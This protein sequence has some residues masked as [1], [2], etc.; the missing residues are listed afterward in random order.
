[1]RAIIWAAVSTLA[2]TTEDKFSIDDQIAMGQRIAQERG[3]QVIDTLIVPGHSRSYR[4]LDKLALDASRKNINA[5]QHLITHFERKDFDV[6]ICRDFNRFARKASLMHTIVET[7]VEDVGARIYCVVDGLMVDETNVDAITMVKGYATNREIKDLVGRRRKGMRKRAERGLA[8]HANIPF[9]HKRVFVQEAGRDKPTELPLQLDPDNAALVRHIAQLVLEGIG[10]QLIAHALYTRFGYAREDGQPFSQMRAYKFMMNPVTWGHI[11]FN[12]NYTNGKGS[13]QRRPGAW[14]WD[15]NVPPPEGVEVYRNVV[16]PAYTGELA[17]ALKAE[18][19][20]R[21]ERGHGTTGNRG[22]RFAGLCVCGGCGANMIFSMSG[23]QIRGKRYKARGYLR[24]GNYLRALPGRERCNHNSHIR[25]EKVQAEF[26]R[27][28]RI[29]QAGENPFTATDKPTN[30]TALTDIDN[31]IARLQRQAGN[32]IMQ[33]ADMGSEMGAIAREQVTRM[34]T[35]LS[36]RK[37]ERARLLAETNYADTLTQLRESSI[38]SLKATN[39]D[40]FWRGSD[41]EINQKLHILLMNYRLVISANE[42]V[43][44]RE[45]KR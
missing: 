19:Y 34:E 2:Q 37:A 5:F 6:L 3:W 26:D 15:E 11:A 1:M 4:S 43:G 40:D 36:E 18:L 12:H 16:P 39:I 7:I 28:L 27:I 32:L 38:E 10:W 41:F 30:N 45:R 8:A 21:H 24:C 42:P 33:L 13:S 22:S 23:T 35:L 29:L 17:D 9:S 25:V 20:R 14:I 44:W 31:E